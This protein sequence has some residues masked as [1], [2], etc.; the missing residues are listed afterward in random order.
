MSTSSEKDP[1]NEEVLKA[2]EHIAT[3]V[4]PS[5]INFSQIKQHMTGYKKETAIQQFLEACKKDPTMTRLKLH[6]VYA[7]LKMLVDNGGLV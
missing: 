1:L 5:K 4:F 7:K 2:L 3:V 6:L